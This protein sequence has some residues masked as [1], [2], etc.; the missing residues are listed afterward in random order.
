[1]ECRNVQRRIKPVYIMHQ[2]GI[3]DREKQAVIDGIKELLKIAKVDLTI[4][5]LA[6]WKERN[7]KNPDGSL[8]PYCSIDWYME[9]GKKASKKPSRLNAEG[10]LP[11][12]RKWSKEKG[13]Y[14]VF[15]LQE[16]IYEP[17][18][19][20]VIG[21][22]NYPTAIISVFRF[23]KLEENQKYECIKTL[24]MHEVGHMF[25]LPSDK[26]KENVEENLGGHCTNNKCVMRQGLVVPHDWIKM[27]HDRIEYGPLCNQ[28][29]NEL[30][31]FFRE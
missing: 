23:R 5:D 30:R 14:T 2:D 24:A 16:D 13:C 17:R 9:E 31:A 12:L 26:R 8:K 15:I 27:T 22:S 10:I 11:H 6:V 28:C 21:Y 7:Y 18:A 25:G 4:S 29:I 20:F 1:M 19:E 3:L